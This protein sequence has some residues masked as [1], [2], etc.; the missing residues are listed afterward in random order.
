[1]AKALTTVQEGNFIFV[2]RASF[3]NY[4]A[5]ACG[6]LMSK[7]Q[8]PF[9]V[10]VKDPKNS[11]MLWIVP[12]TSQVTQYKARLQRENAPDKYRF[13]RF[14]GREQCFNISR[15]FPIAESDVCHIFKAGSKP[16]ALNN[17]D[18]QNLRKHVL[19]IVVA[20]TKWNSI[21]PGI[22][23][24]KLHA[25]VEQKIAREQQRKAQTQSKGKG[26]SRT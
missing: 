3:L 10:A 21:M 8:R 16:A 14:L 18:F 11:E 19:S 9:C 22:N 15:M 2:A 4:Q 13:Y 12:V 6:H 25:N 24:H 7:S 26:I 1:M 20:P 17:K 23:I 5:I